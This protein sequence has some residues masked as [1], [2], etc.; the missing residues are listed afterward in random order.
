MTTPIPP[1]IRAR[2]VELLLNRPMSLRTI[3]AILD[4]SV[5]AIA[6]NQAWSEHCAAAADRDVVALQDKCIEIAGLKRDRDAALARVKD[7]ESNNRYQRGYDAGEKSVNAKLSNVRGNLIRANLN[8]T[9]LRDTR[10]RLMAK[11]AAAMDAGQRN[12]DDA[13][14]DLKREHAE[15]L[16]QIAEA[17]GAPFESGIK[18]VER[19]RE[20][21]ECRK[22][23]ERLIEALEPLAK[24]ADLVSDCRAYRNPGTA[25]WAR[26]DTHS[27][28]FTLLVQD[29]VNARAAIDAARASEGGAK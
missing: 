21:A 14:S 3:E 16:Q 1:T 19:V 9:R 20:L 29:C 12:C 17:L 24:V 10:N 5:C 18:I 25:I 8:I 15:S 27:D 26:T 22:D 7:L 6:V 11:H 2:C 4:Q 13:Y 28:G 23:R